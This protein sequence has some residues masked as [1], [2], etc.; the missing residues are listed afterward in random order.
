MICTVLLQSQ[1]QKEV[2]LIGTMH[3]VPKIVKNAY[4]PMLRKAKKYQPERIYVE[5][6]RKT[7]TVSLNYYYKNFLVYSDS[8]KATLDLKSFE[9]PAVLNKSLDQMT[10]EDFKFLK[11]YYLIQRD[12]A[13][14]KYFQY[15]EVYGLKGKK[16]KSRNENDDLTHKL[17]IH[18]KHTSISSM[19][20]QQTNHLYSKAWRKCSKE[21]RN[22]GNSKALSKLYG[23][24]SRS[25]IW[26]ALT[27]A[28]AK[29]NNKTKKMERYHIINSFRYVKTE[30]EGCVEG[31]KYWDLRN[32]KMAHHL[33]T[34]IEEGN[35]Q[36]N[37]LIVGAGHVVGIK[38]VLE[39]SYPNIKIILYNDL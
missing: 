23:K 12:Y 34:Q 8:V 30:T 18:M 10:V 39:K 14:F 3:T 38:E 27:K 36:K 1:N 19:D 28:L 6:V 24:D 7:D 16:K 11:Q 37:V 31:R 29:T 17:A 22:N 4:S 32:Q 20:D 26:A 35:H 9:N 5:R 13:N 21:G 33:G 2:V 15:L 25:D